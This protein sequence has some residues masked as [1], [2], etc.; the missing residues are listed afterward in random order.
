MNGKDGI[1]FSVGFIGI[2]FALACYMMWK[3]DHNYALMFLIGVLLWGA[4][5]VIWHKVKQCDDDEE[6]GKS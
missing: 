4:C 3:G 6:E 2:Y 1:K 5:V